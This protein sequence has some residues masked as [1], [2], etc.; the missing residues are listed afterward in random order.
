MSRRRRALVAIAALVLAAGAGLLIAYLTTRSGTPASSTRDLTVV[1]RTLPVY[2][3]DGSPAAGKPLFARMGCGVC[4]TVAAA[5]AHGTVGAN[6]DAAPPS[7]DLVLD[8]V[9]NGAGQMPSFKSQLTA[10][11]IRDLAAY[12]VTVTH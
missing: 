10:K 12:V 8:T 5:G 1:Q 2:T 6:L 9:T 11:Q 7:Y 3:G 4:H